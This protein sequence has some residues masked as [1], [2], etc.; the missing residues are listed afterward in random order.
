MPDPTDPPAPPDLPDLPDQEL[1]LNAVKAVMDE[2]FRGLPE[3]RAVCIVMDFG[4]TEDDADPL[5]VF[6]G[7]AEFPSGGKASLT[8]LASLTRRC[9][10]ATE[11][12]AG[13]VRHFLKKYDDHAAALAKTIHELKQQLVR[14]DPAPTGG[15]APAPE[16]GPGGGPTPPGP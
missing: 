1:D 6:R 11:Y 7:P 5:V 3:L 12:A 4:P 2:M 8:A 14:P 13:G 16:P 9:V 10:S 15:P